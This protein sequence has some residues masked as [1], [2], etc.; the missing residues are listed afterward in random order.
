MRVFTLSR[1]WTEPHGHR[2]TWGQMMSVASVYAHNDTAKTRKN[3]LPRILLVS[4]AVKEPVIKALELRANTTLWTYSILVLFSK[5]TSKNNKLICWR[6]RLLVPVEMQ[7]SPISL[8]KC[9]RKNTS[10]ILGVTFNLLFNRIIFSSKK[11][12]SHLCNN[13][14]LQYLCIVL[15]NSI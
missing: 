3:K 8:M 2:W 7:L 10:L 9:F 12:T 14:Q 13:S 11:K 15:L 1:N 4:R 6:P 5:T